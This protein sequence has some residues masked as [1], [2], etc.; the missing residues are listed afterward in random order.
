M[1]ILNSPLYLSILVYIF[2]VFFLLIYK[3][4]LLYCKNGKLKLTGCGKNKTIFS[5]PVILIVISFIL[6]FIFLIIFEVLK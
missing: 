2:L 5:L 6:Y 3:P 4:R 1:N